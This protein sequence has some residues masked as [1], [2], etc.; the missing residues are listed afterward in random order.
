[1]P[2][3]FTLIATLVVLASTQMPAQAD[4]VLGKTIK[5]VWTYR[6]CGENGRCSLGRVNMNVYISKEGTIFDYARGSKGFVIKLGEPFEG[7][8]YTVSGNVLTAR[9]ERLSVNFTINGRGC[10]LSTVMHA[11]G[12][13]QILSQSCS[14]V[15]GRSGR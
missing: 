2:R 15:E 9:A 6:G 10:T 1:M 14:V 11:S 8:V 5:A 12:S 13:G 7:I 3:F 4:A